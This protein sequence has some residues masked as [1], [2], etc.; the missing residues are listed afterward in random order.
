[1]RNQAYIAI[2]ALV[3]YIAAVVT[4]STKCLDRQHQTSTTTTTLDRFQSISA[5]CT[6]A[7][8]SKR[9]YDENYLEENFNVRFHEEM[10]NLLKGNLTKYVMQIKL[11]QSQKM[12]DEFEIKAKEMK[13]EYES[14]ISSIETANQQRILEMKKMYDDDD[15]NNVLFPADRVGN[16]ASNMARVSR[17]SFNTTFFSTQFGFEFMESYTGVKD[18][19]LLYGSDDTIPSNFSSYTN[20]GNGKNKIP[21]I[22]D[23]IVA[24][25]NC[26][27][28]RV[29]FISQ[30]RQLKQ[31]I[32]IVPNLDSFHVYPLVQPTMFEDPSKRNNLIV[33]HTQAFQFKSRYHRVQ[34]PNDVL[35]QPPR[36]QEET[37]VF[38]KY[39]R[40]Y[41]NVVD[42]VLQELRTILSKIAMEYQV[43]IM[44]CNYGQA[45][46]LNNFICNAQSRNINLS[47]LI[48][49]TTDQ[50]TTDLVT[51]FGLTAFY[52][53]GVRAF[54]IFLLY[55]F[56]LKLQTHTS[57]PSSSVSTAYYWLAFW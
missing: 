38:F 43:I 20:G 22:D 49:F 1:M 40:N 9:L 8:I 4:L 56:M 3:A 24:T 23:A 16:F 39:L 36:F 15:N 11:I 48:V 26:G 13:I 28:M 6:T 27:E 53:Q 45:V 55:Q 10:Q 51:S 33:N 35:I 32:A 44:M 29:V 52:D 31:C 19:L 50:E 21:F 47:N 12:N 54:S 57:S 25:E 34:L 2:V 18:L 14:K 41:L 46:L 30:H 7:S 5:N 17:E 42:A 37:T